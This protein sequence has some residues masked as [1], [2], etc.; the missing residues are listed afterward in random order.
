MSTSTNAKSAAPTIKADI[1]PKGIQMATATEQPDLEKMDLAALKKM[2]DSVNEAFTKRKSTELKTLV[3]GWVAK[4]DAIGYSVQ[5]MIDEIR[6]HLPADQAPK[7]RAPRGSLPKTD[8]VYKDV[9]STGAR[10]AIGV[11]YKLGTLT[12]EKKGTVGATKKEFVEAVT[13]G[14]KTWAELKA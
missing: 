13:K 14:G 10:P 3:N 11:P 1:A 7:T 2:L 9:D 5:D 4:A 12:W 8:K 6:T